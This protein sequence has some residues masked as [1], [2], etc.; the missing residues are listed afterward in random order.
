RSGHAGVEYLLRDGRP[1]LGIVHRRGQG[2]R[3]SD[4]VVLSI[5]DV[6]SLPPTWSHFREGGSK[7]EDRYRFSVALNPAPFKFMRMWANTIGL[8]R[9]FQTDAL[10]P[11]RVLEVEP[12]PELLAM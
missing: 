9:N 6:R 12:S 10:D 7:E 4:A 8:R 1:V 11:Q 3:A 2:R 5:F